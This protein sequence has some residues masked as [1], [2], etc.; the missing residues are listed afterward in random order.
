MPVQE[1]LYGAGGPPTPRAVETAIAALEGGYKCKVSSS[2]LAAVSITLLAF[3]KT[4]DHLLMTDSI[5]FPVRDFCDRV[6]KRLGIETTYYD[7]LIG[8]GVAA[9]IR[10]NTKIVY[11]ESPGSETMEVQDVPAIAD[12]AHKHGCLAFL[13]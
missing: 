6:L 1:S 8:R 5:Y 7:P 10:P 2:G 12:V 9:L 3:L 11:C 13:A 4:G